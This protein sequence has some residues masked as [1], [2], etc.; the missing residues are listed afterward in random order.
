MWRTLLWCIHVRMKFEFLVS[1][2]YRGPHAHKLFIFHI[3][4]FPFPPTQNI[5]GR[6]LPRPPSPRPGVPIHPP[7]S[8]HPLPPCPPLDES[9]IDSDR[10]EQ[11]RIPPHLRLPPC[12]PQIDGTLMQTLI[13]TSRVTHQE[14]IIGYTH[15]F[16][17][18]CMYVIMQ[19]CHH[20]YTK[21]QGKICGHQKSNCDALTEPI[22]TIPTL[23]YNNPC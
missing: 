11:F 1:F 21:K 13:I 18:Y 7:L 9:P 3:T 15:I 2:T 17:T 10:E 20:S 23:Y 16:Y 19:L 12:F 8:I 22:K 5:N 14:P 6:P 4:P